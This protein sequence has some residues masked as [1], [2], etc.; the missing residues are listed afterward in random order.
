M[1]GLLIVALAFFAGSSLVLSEI[2]FN[3]NGYSN[4]V[5]TVSPDVPKENAKSVVDGIKVSKDNMLK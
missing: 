4:V 1:K 5:V 2:T 3:E